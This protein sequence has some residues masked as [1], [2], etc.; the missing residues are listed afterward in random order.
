MVIHPALGIV[1]SRSDV[2]GEKIHP[3]LCPVCS[4]SCTMSHIS[5]QTQRRGVPNCFLS[6]MLP[7]FRNDKHWLKGLDGARIYIICSVT[8]PLRTCIHCTGCAHTGDMAPETRPCQLCIHNPNG[9]GWSC[10]RY[11]H[12][13]LHHTTCLSTLHSQK[14]AKT[15]GT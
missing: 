14:T 11:A 1:L 12:Q 15:G 13:P 9:P 4:A 5:G 3:K 6:D 10:C 7:V 2:E 8:H